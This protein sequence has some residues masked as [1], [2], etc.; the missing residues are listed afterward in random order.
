MTH[1][2]TTDD[3]TLGSQTD[4][5]SPVEVSWVA[6]SEG[7]LVVRYAVEPI[8]NASSESAYNE[9]AA[10][11]R[12]IDAMRPSMNPNFNLEWFNILDDTLSWHEETK[13]IKAKHDSQYFFGQYKL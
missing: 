7:R 3:L 8:D 10:A 1:T 4:D 6:D 11:I 12:M 5:Y 13:R 2:R 9:R